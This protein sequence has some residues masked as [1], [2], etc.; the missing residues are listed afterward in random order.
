MQTQYSTRIWKELYEE[1]FPFIWAIIVLVPGYLFFHK[2]SDVIKEKFRQTAKGSKN[3]SNDKNID[4]QMSTFIEN[5]PRLLLEIK[6]EVEKQ[7]QAGV[8]DQQMK[9]L[10]SKQSM[11]QFLVDNKEIIDIIGKPIIKKLVGFIK[12]I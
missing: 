9:G 2:F 7:K 8:T 5:A 6:T 1:Y 11:L 4:D 10:M 3:Y 12:A